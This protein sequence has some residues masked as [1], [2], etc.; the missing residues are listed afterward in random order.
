[1]RD[2]VWS[3]YAEGQEISK[4]P[5]HAYVQFITGTVIPYWKARR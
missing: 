1:M 4:T 3:L 2:E 5:S